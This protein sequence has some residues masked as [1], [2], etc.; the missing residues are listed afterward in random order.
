MKLFDRL[1]WLATDRLTPGTAEVSGKS[2]ALPTFVGETPGTSSASSRKFR[3][4]I[5]RLLASGSDTVPTIWLRAASRTVASAVIVTLASRPATSS[6]TGS[7]NAAPAV[8]VSVR[9]ACRKPGGRDGELIGADPEVGETE[10]PGLIAR[11][12]SDQVGLGVACGD[13]GA[14]DNRPR[15]IS[16]TAA[17]AGVVDRLL[18]RNRQDSR[19]QHAHEKDNSPWIHTTSDE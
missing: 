4:F 1:R 8:S 12:R 10:P 11:R 15:T 17:D 2:C 19:E 16:D 9:R 13:Q 7:S 6:E 3:P 5:G 14:G 18:R